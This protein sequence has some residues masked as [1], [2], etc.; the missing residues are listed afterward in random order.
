MVS[1]LCCH[2]V[3]P[4]CFSPIVVP[5]LYPLAASAAAE[6][7]RVL[8]VPPARHFDTYATILLAMSKDKSTALYSGDPATHLLFRGCHSFQGITK[9]QLLTLRFKIG[10]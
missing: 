5:P 1:I 3:T 10:L 2:S 7:Q 9:Q 8:S 4:P 6:F